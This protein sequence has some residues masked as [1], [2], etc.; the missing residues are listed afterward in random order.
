M[1][2]QAKND[3]LFKCEGGRESIQ[4]KKRKNFLLKTTK[5]L[6]SNYYIIL[7]TTHNLN[8]NH[9][10]SIYNDYNIR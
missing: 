1:R 8:F 10:N 2:T 9:I 5:F 6:L 3:W 7:Y 4:K